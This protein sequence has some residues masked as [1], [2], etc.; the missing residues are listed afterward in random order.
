MYTCECRE[1]C[2]WARLFDVCVLFSPIIPTVYN[3]ITLKG[4]CK[5]SRSLRAIATTRFVKRGSAF[6]ARQALRLMIAISPSKGKHVTRIIN[7][8]PHL[9]H[10]HAVATH[11]LLWYRRNFRLSVPWIH[12]FCLTQRT[13]IDPPYHGDVHW[14]NFFKCITSMSVV[15]YLLII[16]AI[17]GAIIGSIL[18][19]E[20]WCTFPRAFRAWSS[21]SR[22]WNTPQREATNFWPRGCHATRKTDG[23]PR[24]VAA[25]Q[26]RSGVT[27]KL[28][29]NQSTSA[30]ISKS[31]HY[32]SERIK[33]L[34]NHSILTFSSLIYNGGQPKSPFWLTARRFD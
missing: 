27:L 6:L 12:S 10:H 16:W 28:K 20:G 25:W 19:V 23:G 32:Y 26:L 31:K 18:V 5:E 34:L 30:S 22:V 9:S 33:S 2:S 3:F 4:A 13:S 15:M 11:R 7:E 14:Y 8:V 29:I 24:T 1:V 17:N 21:E